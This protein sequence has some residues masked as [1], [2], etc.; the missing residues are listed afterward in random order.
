MKLDVLTKQYWLGVVTDTALTAIAG[1]II[2]TMF[3]AFK[4]KLNPEYVLFYTIFVAMRLERR[5]K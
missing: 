5:L 4:W 2:L 3:H 1:F